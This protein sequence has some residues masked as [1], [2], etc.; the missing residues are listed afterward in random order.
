MHRPAAAAGSVIASQVIDGLSM[1]SY[2]GLHGLADA[3]ITSP[4]PETVKPLERQ[5]AQFMMVDCSGCCVLSRQPATSA[6]IDVST[7]AVSTTML[8]HR[9]V[10][11]MMGLAI[12]PQK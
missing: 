7:S 5:R 10:G 4:P 8:S 11:D 12:I 6:M 9:V 2:I 3:V 1:D